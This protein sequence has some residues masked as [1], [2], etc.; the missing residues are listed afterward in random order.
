[1]RTA[2]VIGSTGL[3]GEDLVEKLARQGS[4][5][6]V[7][8]I[9]RKSKTWSNPKIRT[10]PFDFSNWGDLELQIR[11]FAGNSTLDFFCCLGT[12]MKV[13]KSE[14]A[15]RK[16]DLE[17]VVLFSML[18]QRC[19]AEQLLIVSALGADPKSSVFYNQVKGEMEQTVLQ[20]YS[21]KTYFARPSLLL[22]D[23]KEFRLGE[24]LAI[25]FAPVIS[26]F[27][28]GNLEK[29]EPIKSSHVAQALVVVAAKLRSASQ[30]IENPELHA[31]NKNV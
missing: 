31:L 13:A 8:A 19:R 21:G 18:A 7:L 9:G 23:R 14:E 25:L 26:G 27:L 10:L 1:M 24:R 12:T 22:G 28:I 16:I 29:Y 3:I 6:S 30:F 17:A 15:F 4:W 20:K 11:S 2:V 5:N